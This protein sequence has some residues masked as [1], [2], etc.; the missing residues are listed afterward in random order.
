[1][2]LDNGA[3]K[4]FDYGGGFRQPLTSVLAAIYPSFALTGKTKYG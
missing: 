4:G 2:L 3:G 1:V